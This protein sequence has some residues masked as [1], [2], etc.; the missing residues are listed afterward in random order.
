MKTRKRRRSDEAKAKKDLYTNDS[1]LYELIHAKQWTTILELLTF[2]T[3]HHEQVLKTFI[4]NASWSRSPLYII[5]NDN[6]FLSDGAKDVCLRLIEI[7]GQ[8]IVFRTGL[9]EREEC[10]DL[11][12]LTDVTVLHRACR[13]NDG[14]TSRDGDDNDNLLEVIDKLLDVGGEEYLFWTDSD[15]CTAWDIACST[16]GKEDLEIVKR[17]L[18]VGGNDLLY[19]I[20]QD[21]NGFNALMLSLYCYQGN[22]RLP[23][24]IHFLITRGGE[25]LVLM[26]DS[27]GQTP[28]HHACSTYQT[29]VNGPAIIDRLLE[30]GGKKLVLTM[31]HRDQSVLQTAFLFSVE[32]IEQVVDSFIKV[33]GKALV[34]NVDCRD[35]S[36]LH[37][38]F[39]L[40][41]D[42]QFEEYWKEDIWLSIFHKLLEVGGEELLMLE[43]RHGCTVAHILC[44]NRFHGN[45]AKVIQ[46]LI[47]VGGKEIL[48]Q[49]DVFG[50]T[51]LH[52]LCE[53]CSDKSPEM[54]HD[55]IVA[56]GPEM[57][58]LRNDDGFTPMHVACQ[59]AGSSPYRV[60]VINQLL[61]VGR[62]KIL[63]QITLSGTAPIIETE[64]WNPCQEVLDRFIEVGGER[65]ANLVHSERIER[66][67]EVGTVDEEVNHFIQFL[68]RVIDRGDL[69]RRLHEFDSDDYDSDD[70][71]S[72]EDALDNDFAFNRRVDELLERDELESDFD[73]DEDELEDDFILDY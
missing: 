27:Q 68:H 31:D 73:S 7:G 13:R 32:G 5:V 40:L 66:V 21:E 69:N 63:F 24:I 36:A 20:C 58:F 50:N 9:E 43:D 3:R 2:Q 22:G 49:I 44:R 59:K 41:K 4:S 70:Y 15:G 10:C 11:P 64:R 37:E 29:I 35:D 33:G 23:A 65:A 61:E 71:D 56:G 14:G 19:S 26:R 51:P 67:D 47:K 42:D 54:V 62:Q 45:N 39:N 8:D 52:A 38:L 17:L 28:L 25:K 16:Q 1:H 53:I 55:M 12:D 57:V 34:N 18:D 72:D 30:V 60:E 48:K 46:E 6:N